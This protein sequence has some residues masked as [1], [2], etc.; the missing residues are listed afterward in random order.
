M[1]ELLVLVDTVRG[2]AY[3]AFG[4]LAVLAT[5]LFIAEGRSKSTGASQ[6]KGEQHPLR[7]VA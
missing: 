1:N 6:P 4:A 7:K 2:I 5:G 3:V